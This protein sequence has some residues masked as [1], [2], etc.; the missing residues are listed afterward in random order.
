MHKFPQAIFQAGGQEPIEGRMFTTRMVHDAAQLEQ[1]LSDGWHESAPA[2]AEAF[3]AAE[4]AKL[5]EQGAKADVEETAPPT[6]AELEQKAADLGI[7]VD[8]RWGDKRLADLI[9]LKLDEL[10]EQ[11]A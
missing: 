4:A 2:A 11:G 1:A 3:D 8:K 5:A 9:A 6:R 7:S 10:A